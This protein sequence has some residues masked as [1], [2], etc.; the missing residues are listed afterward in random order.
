MP[1]ETTKSLMWM[2]EL[3]QSIDKYAYME[4]L[5]GIHREGRITGFTCRTFRYNG[6]DV[7]VPIEIEING[8]PMDR[9]PID[10]LAKINLT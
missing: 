5:D 7:D 8:D 1:T 10:R 2:I 6:N 4:T 3:I 9:I